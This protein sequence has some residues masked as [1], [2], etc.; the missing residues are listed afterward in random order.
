MRSLLSASLVL[1]AAC[2]ISSN[3]RADVPVRFL[4]EEEGESFEV[5][6]DLPGSPSCRTPCELALP[7]GRVRARF[8][9]SRSFAKRLTI[10]DR[11]AVVR[12]KER[13]SLRTGF[14]IAGSVVGGA[15]VIGS[16]IYLMGSMMGDPAPDADMERVRESKNRGTVLGLGGIGVGVGVLVS[17][18]LNGFVTNR[19]RA[20]VE[21]DNA[22]PVAAGLQLVGLSAA[23]TREGGAMLGAT[24]EF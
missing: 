21:V 14:G 5:S 18:V 22:R 2:L 13:S 20:S 1:A 8:T 11:P 4:S 16:S 17:S 3:A 23:T 6:I 19:N 15:T 7:P 12:V 24:F 9:G 10:P